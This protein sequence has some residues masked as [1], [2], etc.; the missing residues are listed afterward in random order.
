MSET[1]GQ[2]QPIR[3]RQYGSYAAIVLGL[4]LSAWAMFVGAATSATG[5]YGWLLR[6]WA[7]C[8]AAATALYVVG[9]ALGSTRIRC[10]AVAL[11]IVT[12]VTGLDPAQRLARI[13]WLGR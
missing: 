10:I 3:R 4:P 6:Q 11:L 1:G 8:A 7:V 9:F 5:T 12:L 2:E 13:G